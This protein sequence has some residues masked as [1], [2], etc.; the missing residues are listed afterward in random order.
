MMKH[1]IKEAKTEGQMNR[2]SNRRSFYSASIVLV[3]FTLSACDLTE[4][5]QIPTWTNRVEFP[6]INESVTLDNLKENENIRTQLYS[7]GTDTI[8]AYA[9]TTEMDTQMV[10]DQ[11]AL[12]DI[13]KSFSQS[14]DDVTVSGSTINQSNG[15]DPVGIDPVSEDTPSALGPIELANIPPAPTPAIILRDIFPAVDGL[16]DGDQIVPGGPLDTVWT[17]F[18][19]S[20]FQS[21]SFISGTL[22]LT[23]N[24][25]MSLYL[26]NDIN[27]Q[28]QE[29]S[30]SDTIDIPGATVDWTTPIA[31]STSSFGTLDLQNKILPGTIIIRISG[32]TVGSNG[33]LVTIN[34]SARASSFSIDVEGF[35]LVVSQ[36]NAKVPS[37]TISENGSI[38]LADSENKIEQAQIQ[39][40]SLSIEID[41][42]MAVPADLVITIDSLVDQSGTAF[43]KSIPIA[44]NDAIA[45]MNMIDNYK[46]LMT[47][48][49]QEITYSYLVNTTDTGDNKVTVS[50][51]DSI[52]VTI[53]LYGETAGSQIFFS[54]IQGIIKPQTIVDTG[55]I[56]VSSDSKIIEADISV[57]SLSIDVDNRVNRSGFAGLPT[58][59]LTIPELLDASSQPLTDSLVLQP[60]PSANTLNFDLSEYTLVFADTSSQVLTY[61]TRV[62]TPAGETG[63]YN[64]E[65]SI[66]V[67][68]VVADMEFS[69]VRGYFNQDAI[70]DSNEIA[71]TE[72]TKLLQAVFETGDLVLTMTNEMGVVADVEFKIEEFKHYISNQPLNVN[73]RL[74]DLTTPQDT[75]I[76]LTDYNLVFD[77][78]I[79][80][81]DQAIHY[82]S[83]VALPA[84]KEMT[85]SFSDSILIDVDLTNL[86]ME[87]VTGII[88]PDTLQIA[89]SE[90]EI[91]LP[92]LVADLSFEKV[93][94]DIDFNSTFEIPIFLTLN[95][96]A[97][98]SDN[99]T[100]EIS[101][102]KTV[103]PGD[104][105]VHIDAAALLNIHPETIV[106]SGQAIVG[107]GITESRIEKGQQMSP[108]M[109]LNIPLSLIID[110]PPFIDFDVSSSDSPLPED[111]TITLEE[112]ILKTVSVNLFEFGAR[113]VVLASNDSLA[114]D[115]LAIAA[116]SAPIAD[117]LMTFEIMPFEN[118]DDSAEK[119]TS[120]VILSPDLLSILENRFYTKPEVQ[121]LGTSDGTPSRFFTTDSL[122]ITSWGS[123]SFTV[124]GD[125]IDGAS[126]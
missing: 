49:Q 5:L 121:L 13:H 47:L 43:S 73:F 100:E 83:T 78:A 89:A 27:V 14:V 44:A 38:L 114:F 126:K 52:K 33:Q 18:T 76:D 77:S 111:E 97:T 123:I 26:G 17:N 122:T 35:D 8:Y 36:A 41:N 51:N 94:I 15:F 101:V 32:A 4:K 92:D 87:S 96:S 34:E 1:S 59:I 50:E 112:V 118:T 56:N 110:D 105:I 55:D 120:A 72:G 39:M 3:L 80:G 40:G 67:E 95:L 61:E 16:S 25:N 68:I 69:S 58:I 81:T 93:N 12:D 23:I 28:L 102:T 22:K 64:L 53:S 98:N 75:V 31:P 48:A 42:K 71:L 37:Q 124:H 119:D 65:D 113:V 10:G 21:A 107:D 86:A 7:N 116:G 19:F 74:E 103:T 84:D 70:V 60:N 106:T 29:I 54:S 90:Q 109:Y 24:N 46:L 62:R 85:L 91:N 20:D 45:D 82:V 63:S 88:E 115:S 66:N 6:L 30:G 108:I 117:T 9:D 2:K 104:Q 11:L 125:A 99:V 79:S 57:G